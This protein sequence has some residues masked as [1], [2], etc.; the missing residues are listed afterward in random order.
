MTPSSNTSAS[1]APAGDEGALLSALTAMLRDK[2]RALMDGD[3]SPQALAPLWQPLLDQLGRFTERR[4]AGRS[5]P[6]DAALLAQADAL[7]QEYEGLRHTLELW[8]DALRIA[9][10]KARQQPR[11]P[12]Y[13]QSGAPASRGSLGRG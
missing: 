4:E 7:R 3:A 9:S 1:V 10:D 11:Q 8:S 13:G 5:A 2:R 6:P 12:V